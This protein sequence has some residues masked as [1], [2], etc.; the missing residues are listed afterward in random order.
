MITYH[1][2]EGDAKGEIAGDGVHEAK[3]MDH[4]SLVLISNV[5]V[6]EVLLDAV[7]ALRLRR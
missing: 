1:M 7:N 4:A 5:T 6:V 2:R 3:D